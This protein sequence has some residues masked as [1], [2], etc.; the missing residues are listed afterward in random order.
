[1]PIYKTVSLGILFT[2]LVLGSGNFLAAQPNFKISGHISDSLT[3]EA[4]PLIRVYFSGTSLGAN[5]NLDG[6]FAFSAPPGNYL[7]TIKYSGYYL[8]QDSI[9]LDAD[10]PNVNVSLS[11][12]S[13]GLEDVVISAKAVNPANRIMKNAIRNKN[14]NRMDKIDAYEY[15]AYN[16]LVISFDN[17]NQ[18]VLGR[19][20]LKELRETIQEVMSDS[21]AV[22]SARFKMAVFVSESV[23]RLYFKKP[24]TKREEIL[25][26]NTTGMKGN[27]Y[28][29]LSTIFLQIDLY[30]NNVQFL[31]RQFVSP[32]ADGA[33]LDYDY[34]IVNVGVDGQDTLFGIDIIPKN[35]WSLTFKGRVY[36]DNR[37]WAVNRFDLSLNTD[38]NINFVEDIRIRQ[39]FQKIDSFWVPTILDLDVDFQN[40]ILKRKGGEGVGLLGRT[41]SY[42]YDYKINVP[43]EP[44][45]YQQEVLELKIDAES[46]DST[47]WK[48]H[49]RSTLDK[50]EVLGISLVDSLEQKGIIKSYL[51][52]I[53]IFSYG[54]KEIG[55]IEIGPWWYLIGT[56]PAEGLRTRLGIYTLDAFSLRWYMGAHLAYGFRDKQFKYQFLTK[57]KLRVKP[58]IEIGLSSTREVEQV[59]FENFLIEGTS[60][61]ESSL[62]MVPLTQLNYYW[63]NKVWTYTDIFKG[64]SGEFYLRTKDFKPTKTFPFLYNDSNGNLN[65]HYSVS[66]AGFNLRIS[67]N[68][69]YITSGGDRIY[70]G[71]KY[72]IFNLG[73]ARG[74]RNFVS[75]DFS[76]HKFTLGINNVVKLGRY[77][78]MHYNFK[79]GQIIGALPFPELYVFRGNQ[80]WAW[81]N[82]GF[83]M[84]NYYEFISDRYA[85]MILEYHLEGFLLNR[86]PLFRR[87]KWKEIAGFRSGWGSLSSKN[88]LMNNIAADPANQIVGRTIQAPSAY[89]YMEASAGIG[90]ILKLFR[91][92][93]IWRINY[94][95]PLSDKGLYKN[96]GPG[97]NLGLRFHMQVRF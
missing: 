34:Q 45:F 67:F 51:D 53:Y 15:E 9:H 33:F 11:P 78:K 80:T 31:E 20:M 13:I 92:E 52:K 16:K 59:G 8:F 83:N 19:L 96:L 5:T 32:I 63:E 70:M 71:S 48:S 84:L 79:L 68:E 62:R 1:M 42:L 6:D 43:R 41:T 14:Q 77:G 95:T 65:S 2:L 49:R 86:I 10:L 60:L 93:G 46:K 69:K 29:L 28:N 75:S 87:L 50:S 37:D 25:A 24:G 3:G 40:S 23:S 85:T 82:V 66:E 73:Y 91:I 64:L 12:V 89:P 30:A 61:F 7:F 81:R 39:E 26:V 36:I 17:V 57:Y 27:E 72:P 76:Y 94:L 18:K 4:L 22:D 35:K 54:T 97:N 58:K 55:K 74:F 21:L 88:V 90:N 44:K 56:N 47:Y 38:P